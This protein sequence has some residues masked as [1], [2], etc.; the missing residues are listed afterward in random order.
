MFVTSTQTIL[1]FYTL[2]IAG[3]EKPS[4]KEL[5]IS[6]HNGDH[7]S[8]VRKLGDN[9]EKATNFR[10][11]EVR[12]PYNDPCYV[13]CLFHSVF[14]VKTQ[15]LKNVL[16]Y[17]RACVIKVSFTVKGVTLV[18]QGSKIKVMIPLLSLPLFC[19]GMSKFLR[20]CHS[21]A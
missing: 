16:S 17:E 19:V 9:S 10:S 12:L 13:D 5:H 4:N 7:Y 20:F 21:G 11:S 14:K 3:S 1:W 18:M 15:C 6:Y 2:Q 8:S